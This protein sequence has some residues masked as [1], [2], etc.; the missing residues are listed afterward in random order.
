MGCH[1]LQIF[2]FLMENIEIF[3]SDLKFL[4]IYLS[5]DVLIKLRTVCKDCLA[6]ERN[7]NVPFFSILFSSLIFSP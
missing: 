7:Q 1:T 2:K 4:F 3:A 6:E 5:I